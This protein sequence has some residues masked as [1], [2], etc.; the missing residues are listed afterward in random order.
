MNTI[1]TLES[2][3]GGCKTRQMRYSWWSVGIHFTQ[4]KG[5]GAFRWNPSH[6]MYD[7]IQQCTIQ[8]GMAGYA[9]G[10]IRRMQ[11]GVRQ[12]YPNG[13]AP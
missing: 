11:R 1:D 9:R 7:L 12:K 3:P 13:K 10:L 2:V 8:N 6:I 5:L 4:A